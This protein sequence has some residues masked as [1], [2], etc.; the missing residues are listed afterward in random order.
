MPRRTQERKTQKDA[1]I[2]QCVKRD[3]NPG[4]QCYSGSKHTRPRLSDHRDRLEVYFLGTKFQIHL[5]SVIK[6]SLSTQ[7][8]K[9]KVVPGFNEHH[10]AEV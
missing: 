7:E 6:Y 2:H 8:V 10:G 9:G 4:Y 1:D 5:C 3:S